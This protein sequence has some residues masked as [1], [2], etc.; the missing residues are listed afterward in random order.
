MLT[1]P[2]FLGG[3]TFTLIPPALSQTGFWGLPTCQQSCIFSMLDK[4]DALG[5]ANADVACLCS[6]PHF[7]YGVRDCIL[8]S[9]AQE[10]DNYDNAY[11]QVCGRQLPCMVR[12][13]TFSR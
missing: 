1:K 6:D 11:L 2:L 13:Y 8:Q 4:H 7:V 12:H 10:W 9:C 3:V 5:C